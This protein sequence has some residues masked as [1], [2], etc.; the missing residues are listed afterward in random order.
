MADLE[1]GVRENCFMPARI[2][3][4][5]EVGS[6]VVQIETV[7]IRNK[8]KRKVRFPHKCSAP[9]FWIVLTGSY[10]ETNEC[11][12]ECANESMN[13]SMNESVNEH[14]NKHANAAM[15]C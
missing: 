7:I 1:E 10:I 8:E 11:A 4:A 9:L 5:E 3:V 15:N 12:Y 6:Q 14:A 13:E 2:G